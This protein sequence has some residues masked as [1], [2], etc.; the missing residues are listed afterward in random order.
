MHSTATPLVERIL[1]LGKGSSISW[2]PCQLSLRLKGRENSQQQRRRPWPRNQ[3]HLR[4]IRWRQ[5]THLNSW[6]H[7]SWQWPY[8]AGA[9]SLDHVDQLRSGI[10]WGSR[11]VTATC[12]CSSLTRSRL[13]TLQLLWKYT[14]SKVSNK[15]TQIKTHATQPWV[16]PQGG[17]PW[18]LHKSVMCVPFQDACQILNDV[19]QNLEATRSVNS[20]V[21]HTGRVQTLAKFVYTGFAAE[22][23]KENSNIFKP[24][25]FE[26]LYQPYLDFDFYLFAWSRC[27]RIVKKCNRED[28]WYQDYSVLLTSPSPLC[29]QMPSPF[30]TETAP[31]IWTQAESI[32]V[33]RTINQNIEVFLFW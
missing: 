7:Q 19:L 13:V 9:P 16:Y 2:S 15:C 28:S 32:L 4:L 17:R 14:Q 10:L 26:A 24:S 18:P 20:S 3:W 22:S 11:S 25:K 23:D 8:R 31:N 5:M 12:S 30:V 27:G 29:H 6:P 33:E 21:V 1:V